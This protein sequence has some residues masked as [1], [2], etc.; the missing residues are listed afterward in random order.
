M[1]ILILANND[2]GLYKFRK[3]LIE[4]LVEEHKVFVSLPNGRFIND[5]I[6]LGC[7]FIPCDYLDRHGMNPF[8]ELKLLMYY[9]KIL[10]EYEPDIVFTYTIKPNVYGGM[11]C[12]KYNIPYVANI[13]GLGTAVENEGVLQKFMILL[14]KTG[15]RKA[16]KVFFQNMDNRAFMLSRNMIKGNYDMLPG[17][18]VNL[19][20]Y[21]VLPYP[22]KDTI[23]FV[24]IA[25]IMKE[26]GIDQYLDAAKVIRKKYP[27]TRF[28]V[29][30][31]CEQNYGDLLEQLQEEGIIIYHGLVKDM[32]SM[33]ANMN[34]TIHPSYYPEGLSNVLLES[35]A[36][37]RPIITTDRAGCRELIDDG[38]NG[39]VCKEKD[40]QDLI[41]KIEKFLSLSREE[42]MKM[43]VAGRKK[44]EQEFD[45]NIVIDKY[46]QEINFLEKKER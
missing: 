37:G 40:S 20:Q 9:K 19:L 28:H 26:K 18:G 5:I 31:E 25:R 41:E 15:I 14:Y 7:E 8:Q 23:D 3:E 21:Q 11:M 34:C 16:Q 10:E 30:G 44:V 12:A 45:R 32:V 29:C 39:F 24:F 4:K 36:C 13:T 35:C 38:I 1:R 46:V 2:V 6:G 33:H 27:Y 22:Q 17:S 42:R 43:G